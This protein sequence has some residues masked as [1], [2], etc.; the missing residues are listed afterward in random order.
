MDKKERLEL[1]ELLI[2]EK[3]P[4]LE[5]LENRYPPRALKKNNWVTRVAPSPTG[6]PHF[7]LLYMAL[8]NER[9]AHQSGG[10]FLLR[11]EDTDEKRELKNSRQLIIDTLRRLQIPIDEGPE[12]GGDYGPYIQSRRRQ[13]YLGTVKE[14]IRRGRAYPCFCS[15]QELALVR[16]RQERQKAQ[17]GYYGR[18]A[19]CRHLSLAEIK[20]KLSAGRRFVIRFRAPS[21]CS[22]LE[23]EDLVR[24]RLT[25]PANNIDYVLYKSDG[26]GLTLPVYHL[27]ATVDDHLQRISHVFRGEEW[28]ASLPLHLQIYRAL[29]WQLPRFGHLMPVM[30]LDG[31]KKRKLS[32]RR[33]PEAGA[34]YYWR[35]GFPVRAVKA[36]IL[37]LTDAN[38]DDWRRQYLLVPLD[39][40]PIKVK[41][42]AHSR[43]PLLDMAKMEQLA[44]DE[45]S[46][47]VRTNVGEVYKAILD[48]AQEYRPQFARVFAANPDYSRA[49]LSIEKESRKDISRWSEAEDVFG[50]FYDEL[51]RPLT[52]DNL[53]SERVDQPTAEKILSEFRRRFSGRETAEEW[54]L[55]MR[56]LSQGL[57]YAERA[58]DWRRRPDK[59]RGH[60]GDVA[61]VVRLAL[62]A[63]RQ[64]PNLYAIAKIMGWPRIEQRL[65][66]FLKA[67]S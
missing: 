58:A 41:R 40:F 23:I 16:R 27:A 38:F 7:G 25:L 35:Q 5:E 18:W 21:G 37:R 15:P 55:K 47:W 65:G 3:V 45:I 60:I 66:H 67:D 62:T 56:Q 61:M 63:R 39:D 17:P 57:G 51:Y 6:L 31:G 2:P 19:R 52:I 11:I 53:V 34:E 50:Y 59:Y 33:D 24:G 28:L 49:I 48:W 4:G 43:G 54:A 9:L 13:I 14:L 36:Y 64:T 22:R 10:R 20:K 42:L 32:K 12:F 8:I 46:A 29:G 44:R 26:Y 1:A 30:K